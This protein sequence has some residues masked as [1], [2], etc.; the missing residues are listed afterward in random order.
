M[1]TAPQ[2]ALSRTAAH[3]AVPYIADVS[4][5]VWPDDSFTHGEAESCRFKAVC[6]PV[7]VFFG[8]PRES[9]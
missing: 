7:H 8:D 9:D 1:P 6:T 3:G 4:S 5:R 2:Y